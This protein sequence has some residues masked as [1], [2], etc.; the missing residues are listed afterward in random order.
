MFR[1]FPSITEGFSACE[2]EGT[3][4]LP[5]IVRGGEEGTWASLASIR[6]QLGRESSVKG[7]SV[8]GKGETIYMSGQDTMTCFDDETMTHNV[9]DA[10]STRSATALLSDDMTS[11]STESRVD[12]ENWCAYVVSPTS[13]EC[14]T[15]HCDPPHGSNWQYLASGEKVWYALN[16]NT[17]SLQS[18]E[19]STKAPDMASLSLLHDCYRVVISSGDFISVP[20]HWAHAVDTRMAAIGLSGYSAIPTSMLSPR[21]LEGTGDE[22]Y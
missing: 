5:F 13:H 22:D 8:T 20:I 9:V 2:L 6:K 17:F 12:R 21:S 18:F 19:G 14:G 4:S 10:E 15:L 11:I 1:E 16:N 7:Y 3:E